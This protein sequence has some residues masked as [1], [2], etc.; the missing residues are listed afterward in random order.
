M[1]YQPHTVLITGCAGFIGS[2]VTVYLVQKY[3]E[4]Q[5]V[6]FDC[7]SYCANIDNFAEINGAPN[8]KFYKGNLLEATDLDRVFRE[9]PIDTVIHYA[10]FHTS[11]RV[12]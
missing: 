6:G 9:N 10:H 8:W 7:I 2:N 1:T 11:T 12:F 3:P 4:I 5:F